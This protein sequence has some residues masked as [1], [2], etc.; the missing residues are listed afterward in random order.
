[1]TLETLV[2]LV[3]EAS[4]AGT[5]LA[6]GLR[7]RRADVTYLFRNPGRFAR[8]FLSILVIMPLVALALA[9]ALDLHPAV[10]VALLALAVSPVPPLLPGKALRKGG[11]R[12]YVVG[13][14]FATALLSALVVPLAVH[15]AGLALD[16]PLRLRARTVAG[17]VLA[18]VLAPLAAGVAIRSLW[19]GFAE[20]AARPVGV[21]ATVLLVAACQ[22]MMPALWG[23]MRALIGN[24]TLLAIATFA[25]AGVVAGHLLGGPAREDRVVLALATAARHPTVAI[26]AAAA[27]FPGH[28]EVAPAVV[29]YLVVS[30]VVSAVYLRLA[31]PRP[32]RHPPPPQTSVR[33]SGLSSLD[34]RRGSSHA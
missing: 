20:R 19:P 9:A 5:V 12:S 33:V 26:S 21:A 18:S 3:L 1:M 27:L 32:V 30:A 17:I 6:V 13:L 25:V 31:G 11:H 22:P 16:L 28:G 4:I 8:S 2:P 23:A 10:K 15:L 29:L 7:T 14:L 24:G 34:G